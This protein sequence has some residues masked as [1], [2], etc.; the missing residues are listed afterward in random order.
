MPFL[1][2]PLKKINQKQGGGEEL[3]E[4]DPTFKKTGSDRISNAFVSSNLFEF[5][6]EANCGLTILTKQARV[7]NM[8]LN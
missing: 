3:T 7:Y 2:L 1:K 6:P 5:I 4:P 8:K